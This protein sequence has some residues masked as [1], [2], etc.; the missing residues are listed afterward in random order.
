MAAE[1][2]VI[3]E[4]AVTQQSKVQVV[5]SYG[6]ATRS[7]KTAAVAATELMPSLFHTFQDKMDEISGISNH[8]RDTTIG[9]SDGNGAASQRK[10]S[11]RKNAQ[12]DAVEFLT[13]LLDTLHEELVHAEAQNALAPSQ[14]S[15]S[16]KLTE[17]DR[18]TTRSPFPRNATP[19]MMSIDGEGSTLNSRQNS[20]DMVIALSRQNSLSAESALA[21]AESAEDGWNTVSKASKAKVKAVVVDA[22]SKKRAASAS[23]ASVISRLFHGTL[24]YKYV[25]LRPYY[26]HVCVSAHCTVSSNFDCAFNL[27]CAC[28][29]CTYN[30]CR[31]EVVYKAKKTNS[32]TF[33]QFHCLTLDV[34]NAA[35]ASTSIDSCLNNYFA[36]EVSAL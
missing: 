15:S 33:Q 6:A 9:A 3:Q 1:F 35:G 26:K 16:E 24:R 19:S 32:V 21:T 12:Q 20:W 25:Y 7:S 34:A 4:P 17:S 5:P 8:L 27:S 10:L 14:Y 2:K 23:N 31:S 18:L 36:E 13:F 11:A 29:V 22:E 28:G 30:I